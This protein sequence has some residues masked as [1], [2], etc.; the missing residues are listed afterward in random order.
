MVLIG[1]FFAEVRK[2][3][4]HILFQEYESDVICAQYN[5]L[6]I[7]TRFQLKTM[8]SRKNSK[9]KKWKLP[10]EIHNA[11]IENMPLAHFI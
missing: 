3:K 1:H 6:V 11:I 10:I 9:H 8:K 2:Y 7:A 4:D 5:H